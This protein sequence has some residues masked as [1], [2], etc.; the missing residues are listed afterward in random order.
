MHGRSPA[1]VALLGLAILVSA[2]SGSASFSI[3][4]Q[5][6][7]E[8]AEELIAGDLAEQ[9]GLGALIPDCPAVD[10]PEVGTTFAC[11]ATTADGQIIT[12]DGVVDRE[13]HID[14]KATNLVAG[15]PIEQQLAETLQT[16]NPDAG[17]TADG[18]DC[19]GEVIVL[20]DQQLT[21]EIRPAN[22]PMQIA[23]LTV[24]DSATGEFEFTLAPGPGG[25]EEQAAQEA[26]TST[27][28]ATSTGADASLEAIAQAV[29]LQADDF[30]AGWSEAPAT[31]FDTDYSSIA[32]CEFVGDLIDDDG[33][34]V[35]VDSS[36][37]SMGDVTVDHSVRVYADSQTATEIV[38]V[39]AEQATVDCVV[40][41]AQQQAQG[42]LNAGELEP[43][44][45]VNFNLQSY[46][47]HAGEPRTTN[48]ELTSTLIAPDQQ[49]VV[50]NDQYFVQV[51]RLVSRIGVVSPDAPWEGTPEVLGLVA[52]RMAAA[53]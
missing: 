40:Q 7:E 29:V 25:E 44:E 20:V 26:T 52:E 9:I 1:L 28:N 18:V 2:C 42:S 45:E 46:E 23:T 4:G 33:F 17:L 43:F 6:V 3:G 50:I 35:E 27:S 51:G 41:G 14:L 10:D 48:L 15:P 34:L 47:D 13:D 30:A 22:A 19:G 37:F 31:Q 12:I 36:E 32:G 49:L 5:T 16:Q 39:W 8:A 11:T 21:C 53:E 38:L 24:I